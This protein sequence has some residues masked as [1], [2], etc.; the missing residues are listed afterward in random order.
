M[1]VGRSVDEVVEQATKEFD[2]GNY[3]G[4]VALLKPLLKDKLSPQ[5]EL[6]VAMWLS[7]CY[8]F[9][10][11]SK[12]ALPHAE[13]WVVLVQE[14]HGPRSLDHAQ[15]LKELC[16][17]HQ[18]LK[19]FPAAR[20]AIV[21]ALAIMDERGL[22]QDEQYGGMLAVL[23]NLDREQGQYKEA[24]V[25]FNK[26]KAV[27]VQYKEGR[28]YGLVLN[29]MALCHQKL[30]QWNEAVACH[31]E[32]VEHIRN[33]HGSSHPDYATALY[34]LAMLFADLKQYEEAIPRFEEALAIRQKVFGDQHQR[35]VATAK[36][37]ASA[38]EKGQQSNRHLINPG[39]EF[40]MCNQCGRSRST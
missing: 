19:A 16:M 24:L 32:A 11:D 15:A 13:R 10:E 21:E 37:L 29:S 23:G 14:L 3:R 8:R 30:H 5:Q 26:A 9:L 39:H 12:A 28:N 7:G 2:A 33:L 38:R 31:K 27:L 20:K 36:D 40:R 17:V 6:D 34:N 22:Q 1:D 35:T 25:I 18:G 4:A